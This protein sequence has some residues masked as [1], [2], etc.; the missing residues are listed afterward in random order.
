MRDSMTSRI[1]LRSDTL[2][3]PTAE[4]RQ[5]IAQAVVQDSHYAD[6]PNVRNLT[7]Y[8]CELLGTEDAI[9]LP[10]ATMANEIALAVHAENGARQLFGHRFSHPFCFEGDGPARIAHLMMRPIDAEYGIFG[11]ETLES[12]IRSAYPLRQGSGVLLVEN[13]T[14]LGGGAVW[15]FST[16][17]GTIDLAREH[18]WATHLDGA[19][20][21][22]AV[23]ASG[24]PASEYAHHFDTVT[25]CF[26]KGLAAP[27][28]AVLAGRN[29]C[30]S[31]ARGFRSMFGGLMSMEGM[32]AVGALHALQNNVGR[33]AVDHAHA[34]RLAE[35]IADLPGIQIDIA[36]VQTN[37]VVFSA[38]RQFITAPQLAKE[39]Q[40]LGVDFFAFDE[41]LCRLV[42]YLDITTEAIDQCIRCFHQVLTEERHDGTGQG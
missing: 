40:N 2:S 27:I 9:F 34:R 17:S 23:V 8:V 33:L 39:M 11:P 20:L 26:S 22:N 35:G 38:D 36:S 1:D 24:M 6:D 12:A 30:I 31:K 3:Q 7:D 4:I 19:R 25:L 42:T 5:R 13:S 21:M 28:G 10:T 37:I 41:E 32:L 29:E 15:P 18:G 14:N 16:L